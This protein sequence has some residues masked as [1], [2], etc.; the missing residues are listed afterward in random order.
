MVLR[1][2]A[3]AAVFGLEPSRRSTQVQEFDN[4]NN[5][6]ENAEARAELEA[7]LRVLKEG[8]VVTGTV[9]RVNDDYV[10]VDVGYKSEGTIN[11]NEIT[12]KLC[13]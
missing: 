4:Q 1:D 3:E 12:H 7:A 11:L 2:R 10:M 5:E 9:V 8:E 6:I 13:S